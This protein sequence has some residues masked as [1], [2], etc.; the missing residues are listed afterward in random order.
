M[1]SKVHRF[2]PYQTLYIECLYNISFQ[3]TRL[4][5]FARLFVHCEK[6]LTNKLMLTPFTLIWSLS[7]VEPS[8]YSKCGMLSECLA[9]D[10]TFEWT[11]PRVNTAVLFKVAT[12]NE[13]LATDI[14]H[15]S[16]LTCVNSAVEF[17]MFFGTQ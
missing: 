7:C 4:F 15:I 3:V 13:C 12:L 14:T 9:T 10:L 17:E 11:L 2:S 6:S 16:L 1:Q 8:V 5:N